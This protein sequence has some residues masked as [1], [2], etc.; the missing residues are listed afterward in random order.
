MVGNKN[1]KIPPVVAILFTLDIASKLLS[2]N[3]FAIIGLFIDEGTT[4]LK[5]YKNFL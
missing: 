1:S 4:P 3:G 5:Q 2:Q